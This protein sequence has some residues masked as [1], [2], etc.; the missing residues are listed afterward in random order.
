MKK[1]VRSLFDISF[2]LTRSFELVNYFYQNQTF[3]ER[4][5]LVFNIYKIILISNFA[6]LDEFI[7]LFSFKFQFLA[8]ETD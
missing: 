8:E 1:D 5:K 6:S 7:L 4:K 3:S 2:L